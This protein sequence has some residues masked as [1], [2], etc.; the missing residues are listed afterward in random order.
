MDYDWW[1]LITLLCIFTRCHWRREFEKETMATRRRKRQTTDPSSVKP[2]TKTLFHFFSKPNGNGVAAL[3]L[4]PPKTES[5]TSSVNEEHRQHSDGAFEAIVKTEMTPPRAV[6]DPDILHIES[7]PMQFEATFTEENDT[8]SPTKEERDIDPFDR[9]D[10]RDEEFQDEESQ[11]EGLDSTYEGVDD[12]DEDFDIK[13]EIIKEE[14]SDPNIDDG[15]T[16]PFCNFSFK[17]L[18]EN[19]SHSYLN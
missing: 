8:C 15:P 19:V 13:Q 5:D 2:D 1:E 3:E 9:M 17:G 6:G 10:F 12:I 7:K 11:D 14:L 18:P 16:C 4:S